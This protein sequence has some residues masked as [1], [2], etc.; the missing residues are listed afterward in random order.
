MPVTPPLSTRCTPDRL[1]AAFE[2]VP[3]GGIDSSYERATEH[4][5]RLAEANPDAAQV[6]FKVNKK[7]T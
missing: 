4:L 6:I 3:G 2:N 7:Q 5:A 1:L